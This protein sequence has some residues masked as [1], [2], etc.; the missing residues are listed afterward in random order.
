MIRLQIDPKVQNFVLANI[1]HYVHQTLEFAT[2]YHNIRLALT[3]F[4]V[5][6]IHAS[7]CFKPQLQKMYLQEIVT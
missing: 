7:V 1:S 6:I 2:L 5:I 4:N 3:K